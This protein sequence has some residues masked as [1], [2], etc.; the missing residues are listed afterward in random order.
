MAET[1]PTTDKEVISVTDMDDLLGTP[2]AELVMTGTPDEPEKPSF[3]QT[4]EV[5][6]SFMDASPEELAAEKAA[7]EAKA[8]AD[9]LEE[10]KAEAEAKRVEAA[11][12]AEANVDF[13]DLL[14]ETLDE[15]GNPKTPGRPELDKKGMAQLAEA[16]IKDKVILP[17]EDDEKQ[18]Q[19]YTLDDYKELFSMNFANQ[20]EQL[21]AETPKEFFESLPSELQYAAKYVHD[22]GSDLKGLFRAL[23]ASEETKSLD[24]SNEGGQEEVARNFL[25]ASNFGTPEEIQ[26]QI[27][28]WKDLDKLEA[29]A[30]QF[31]PKM[32]AMQEQLVVRQ[33]KEQEAKKEQRA[34]ASEQY[35]NSVYDTLAEGKLGELKLNNK[36]QNMLYQGLV[37]PNFQSVSGQPT[38]LFGHLIEKHQYIE[39]NHGLIAEALWLLQDPEG[40]R[41]E[42][43]KGATNTAA[44]ET[45]RQLKIEQANKIA[46]G[47]VEMAKDKAGRTAPGIKRGKVDFFKRQ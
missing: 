20:K 40:Y 21:K 42:I 32:D 31:K 1:K 44:S 15:A 11:K 17:F 13:D 14:D 23:A 46:G 27:E 24:I 39:P 38:N 18:L 36:T 4:K 16:L 22:G 3:F 25:E 19:D 2:G 5:D 10:E 28:S 47:D 34:K 37:Q 43:S 41:K 7:A 6:L 35:A 12:A 26:E 29:K 8:A 9:A 30:K 33:V 45:A